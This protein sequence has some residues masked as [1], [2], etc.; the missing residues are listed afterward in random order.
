M[1]K[2]P[3]ARKTIRLTP[4]TYLAVADAAWAKAL[5][6]TNFGY[7]EIAAEMQISMEQATRIVRG[8]QREGA[9]ELVQE[10]VG[11]TRR[12]WRANP[13]FV[14]IEPLRPRTLEENLWFGMR[15]L[16]SFTPT[17]L[18]AHATTEFL[19]VSVEQAQTYCRNLCEV[20]YLKVVRPAAPNIAR[21]AIYRL[22]DCTGVRPPMI[23]RVP[24]VVDQ[25]TG[26]TRLLG[27]GE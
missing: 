10:S 22:V 5:R 27:R 7:G 11:G 6:M 17:D 20:D 23:R 12:M 21:E 8:W 18:A 24:A 16:G 2:S 19:T 4:D 1:S 25:N 3:F 26:E 9:I 14:R 15:R 13:D